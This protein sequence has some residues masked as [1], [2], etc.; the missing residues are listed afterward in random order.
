MICSS[1]ATE[2]YIPSRQQRAL[3]SPGTDSSWIP[4]R[5]DFSPATA[6]PSGSESPACPHQRHTTSPVTFSRKDASP[7]ASPWV[8]ARL[9]GSCSEPLIRN[10]PFLK[11][12]ASSSVSAGTG[13]SL[14][15][16][17]QLRPPSCRGPS[18]LQ[19]ASTAV[20]TA[21]QGAELSHHSFSIPAFSF[22]KK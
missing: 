8:N 5:S 19:E 9:R 2:P 15:V 21:T 20:P 18:S 4:D 10:Q 6:F 7:S 13:A 16:A 11:L 14:K 1:G 17:W 22:W 12:I 3:V